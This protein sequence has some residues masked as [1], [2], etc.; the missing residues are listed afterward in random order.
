MGCQHAAD[1]IRF[2]VYDHNP[3]V[4]SYRL[5]VNNGPR[6]LSLRMFDDDEI[7][8]QLHRNSNYCFKKFAAYALEVVCYNNAR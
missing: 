2:V 7:G 8:K 3:A 5:R 6:P 4:S 1:D